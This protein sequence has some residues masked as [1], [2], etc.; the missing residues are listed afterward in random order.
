MRTLLAAVAVVGLVALLS[1]P[2]EAGTPA[3]PAPKVTQA[4]EPDL[5]G[6]ELLTDKEHGFSKLTITGQIYS[7]YDYRR[8]LD[9]FERHDN[10][11][12][13]WGVT[14]VRLGL[15]FKLTDNVEAFVQPQA[16]YVWGGQSG[17]NEPGNDPYYSHTTDRD[18]LDIYQAYVVLKPELGSL[19]TDLKLGRQELVFDDSQ[20]I[21]GNNSGNGGLSFDAARLDL[22]VLPELTTSLFGAK[23]VE[24]D[25]ANVNGGIQQARFSQ[26]PVGGGPY[27]VNDPHQDVNLFGV[28]NTITLKDLDTRIDV[29]GLLLQSELMSESASADPIYAPGYNAGDIY[30]IGAELNIKPIGIGAAGNL[31]LYLQGATQFGTIRTDKD[32]KN[33]ITDAYAFEGEIG[34][35]PP[36]VMSPRVAFGA[37]WASGTKDFGNGEKLHTFQPFYGNTA[38]R[39]GDADMFSLSNISAIYAKLEFKPLDVEGLENK[40]LTLGGAW[41]MFEADEVNETVGGGNYTQPNNGILDK[42]GLDNDVANEVD[43]FADYQFNKNVGARATWAIVDPQ[44]FIEHNNDGTNSFG[45][46]NGQRVLVTLDV[47]W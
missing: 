37:A 44:A 2:A 9:T 1:L 31:D 33:D 18:S 15:D 36:L 10:D 45:N 14:R 25:A 29:Y 27:G 43:I 30:T 21:L 3:K 19:Q 11:V 4:A 8:N 24:N 32:T 28:W 35:L 26:T 7:F 47:K 20:M 5:G 39:L 16:Y 13:D 12:L 40:K 6:A 38:N 34:Y 41:F 42:S 22:K 23:V 46:H 17:Y